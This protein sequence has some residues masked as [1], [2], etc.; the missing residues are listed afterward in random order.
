MRVLIIANDGK[1][2]IKTINTPADVFGGVYVEE[3]P[4]PNKRI[5][6]LRGYAVPM[7]VP[8][9]QAITHRAFRGTAVFSLSDKAGKYKDITEMAICEVKKAYPDIIF[10]EEEEKCIKTSAS[11]WD[12]LKKHV[13]RFLTAKK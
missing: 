6:M 12:A 2:E 11:W 10:T 4:L 8:L 1:A 9:N 3:K 5:T 7:G 13:A